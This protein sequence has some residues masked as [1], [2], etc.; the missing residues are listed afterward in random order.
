MALDS[1]IAPISWYLIHDV[2]EGP[3]ELN[4]SEWRNYNPKRAARKLDEMCREV[5]KGVMPLKSYV[6][7]HPAT[8]L[9]HP[10]QELLCNWTKETRARLVSELNIGG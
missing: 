10:E 5:K 2:N 4:F 7:F 3:K 9:S 1:E 6:L 8:R